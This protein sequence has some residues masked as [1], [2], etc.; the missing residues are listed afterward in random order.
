MENEMKYVMALL[1]IFLGLPILGYGIREFR[2]QDCRIEM[3][4]FGK[5]IEEIKEICK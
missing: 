4:K 5:G 3:S 2:N 1:V